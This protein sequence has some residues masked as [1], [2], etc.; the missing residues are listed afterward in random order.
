MTCYEN[1][2]AINP[3]YSEALKGV[4]RLLKIST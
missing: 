4:Q 3:D 2:L 1:A